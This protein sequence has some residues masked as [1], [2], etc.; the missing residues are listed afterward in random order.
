SAELAE[1]LTMLRVGE[2]ERPPG[3][4]EDEH[5][6][7]PRLSLPGLELLVDLLPEER[8]RPLVLDQD[9]AN[10]PRHVEPEPRRPGCDVR[11]GVERERGLRRAALA[12]QDEQAAHWQQRVPRRTNERH[13]RLLRDVDELA[14]RYEAEREVS[15]RSRN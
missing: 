8:P 7:D 1:V 4:L 14:E 5:V 3:L 10:R 15:F 12:A 6:V 2:V 11:D 9:N 13:G